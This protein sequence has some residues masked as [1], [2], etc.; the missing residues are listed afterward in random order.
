MCKRIPENFCVTLLG[1]KIFPVSSAKD[2]GMTLDACLSYNK[3]VTDV[4][5]KLN[6]YSKS[7]PD[8]SCKT[9]S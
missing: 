5:S 7:M 6:V 9:S 1:K 3:H 4:A 8:K 2:L